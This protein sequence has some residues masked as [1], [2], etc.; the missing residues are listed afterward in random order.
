VA[1]LSSF[2]LAFK[3][4]NN[5]L[6]SNSNSFA[7]FS[8]RDNLYKYAMEFKASLQ[9]ELPPATLLGSALKLEI[10]PLERFANAV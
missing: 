7:K 4:S 9:A 5:S 10:I 6:E 1:F 3:Y 8:S 2:V